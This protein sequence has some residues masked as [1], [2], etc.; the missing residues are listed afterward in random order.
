M[1]PKLK[2]SCR[3]LHSITTTPSKRKNS[4][5][6]SNNFNSTKTSKKSLSIPRIRTCFTKIKTIPLAYL[7]SIRLRRKWRKIFKKFKNKKGNLNKSTKLPKRTKRKTNKPKLRLWH[8]K[9]STQPMQLKNR[10][11]IPKKSNQKNK[12]RRL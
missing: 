6:L 1:K 3:P 12:N 10:S 11:S 5:T 4:T 2:L 9:K 7:K 8:L